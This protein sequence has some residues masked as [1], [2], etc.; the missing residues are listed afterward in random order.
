[1]L[2]I[3]KVATMMATAGSLL[4]L[5]AGSAFAA[6]GGVKVECLGVCGWINLG[7]VCDRVS[8]GSQPVAVSCDATSAAANFGSA[9]CGS[10]TCIQYGSYSRVD[11]VSAYCDDGGGHDAVVTCRY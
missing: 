7:Q 6:E 5:S 1:M 4:A 2:S 11:A 9:A 10:G 8:A 3:R